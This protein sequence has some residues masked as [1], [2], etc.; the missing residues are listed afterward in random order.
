[1]AKVFKFIVKMVSFLANVAT[2]LAAWKQLK[3]LYYKVKAFF[4]R[5][6]K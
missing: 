3:E 1:M 2:I 4:K 6:E 5:N